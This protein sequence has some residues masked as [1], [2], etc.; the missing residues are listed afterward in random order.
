[1]AT[2]FGPGPQVRLAP[3]STGFAAGPHVPR[4]NTQE[5]RPV[6]LAGTPS[7]NLELH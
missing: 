3:L 4:F 1:M 2:R 7:Q 5:E 6:Y